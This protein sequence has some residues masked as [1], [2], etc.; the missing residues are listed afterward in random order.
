MKVD[1]RMSSLEH[2]PECGNQSLHN[3]FM[4]ITSFCPLM[5]RF[6]EDFVSFDK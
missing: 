5:D 1:D 3:Y 6:V 4:K 2:V